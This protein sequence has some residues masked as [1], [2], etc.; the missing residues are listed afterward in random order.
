MQECG[1]SAEFKNSAQYK[2]M[3]IKMST[4]GVIGKE[5]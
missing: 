5:S 1:L 4:N 2:S 3:R